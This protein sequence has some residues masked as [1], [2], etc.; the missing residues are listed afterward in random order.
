MRKILIILAALSLT[1]CQTHKM[2]FD[3]QAPKG[4]NCKSVSQVNAELENQA[5]EIISVNEGAKSLKIWFAP[6]VDQH[7][8]YREGQYIYTDH[9]ISNS[10]L[11]KNK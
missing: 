1:A 11:K 5:E 2:T 10:Y 9:N 7:N 6:Y 4:S 3:C 8:N